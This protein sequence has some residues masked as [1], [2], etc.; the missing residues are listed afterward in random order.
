[1]QKFELQTTQ[2]TIF[3]IYLYNFVKQF[4]LSTGTPISLATTVLL[5]ETYIYIFVMNN[6]Q[7]ARISS[8]NNSVDKCSHTNSHLQILLSNVNNIILDYIY[9]NLALA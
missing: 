3:Q 1:M 9:L 2:S 4:N 7:T 5:T 6:R 8:N